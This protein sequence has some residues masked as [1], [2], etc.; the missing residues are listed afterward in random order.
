MRQ[1]P[2]DIAQSNF[3]IYVARLIRDWPLHCGFPN[4]ASTAASLMPVTHSLG[5]VNHDTMNSRPQDARVKAMTTN[6]NQIRGC[7]KRARPKTCSTISSADSTGTG[8]SYPFSNSVLRDDPPPFSPSSSVPPF[9]PSCVTDGLSPQE[10]SGTAA[11]SPANSSLLQATLPDTYSSSPTIS[12]V[13]ELGGMLDDEDLQEI[14]MELNKG[15]MF[16]L[17]DLEISG[18]NLGPEYDGVWESGV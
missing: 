15:D 3:H 5:S 4:S 12:D 16:D 11:M 2:E 7:T 8:L 13:E 6:G 10:S 1:T 14:E 9:Y 18:G 17:D